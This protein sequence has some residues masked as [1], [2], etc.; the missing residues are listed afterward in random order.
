M[1][2]LMVCGVEDIQKQEVL[3]QR[4]VKCTWEGLNY[5]P[6]DFHVITHT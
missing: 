2:Q 5:D 4:F 3:E 1:N 6:L